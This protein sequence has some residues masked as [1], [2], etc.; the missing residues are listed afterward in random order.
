LFFITVGL[1]HSFSMHLARMRNDHYHCGFHRITRPPESPWVSD[2]QV[3][4]LLIH[5]FVYM[6]AAAIII[7]QLQLYK[8]ARDVSVRYY[9]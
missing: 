6:Y 9:Y 2:Q 7:L 3:V 8:Y 1:P 5:F 4:Q